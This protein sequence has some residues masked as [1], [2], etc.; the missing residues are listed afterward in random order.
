MSVEL[1][2]EPHV[3]IVWIHSEKGKITKQATAKTQKQ[4]SLKTRL[5]RFSCLLFDAVPAVKRKVT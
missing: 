5:R 1:K 4:F 2:K 3:R